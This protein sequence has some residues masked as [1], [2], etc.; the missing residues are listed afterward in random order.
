MLFIAKKKK[1][2]R[3]S[4]LTC[5]VLIPVQA[6]SKRADA[7]TPSNTGALN[8][9]GIRRRRER[10]VREGDDEAFVVTRH[11]ALS[12]LRGHTLMT[13][14]ERGREGVS[15]FLTKGREVA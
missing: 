2:S 8:I 14:E 11:R 12:L 1:D 10:G 15:Q 4:D 13:S 9:C 7:L 3:L 6:A 5:A